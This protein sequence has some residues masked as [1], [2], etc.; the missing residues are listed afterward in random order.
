M[1]EN[2]CIVKKLDEKD[3]IIYQNAIN[4]AFKLLGKKNVSLI[5]HGASFPSA[6]C[7]N[8]GMGSPDNQG[9]KNLVEFI[10]GIF[11]SIQLGPAGKTKAIDSSPYTGTIFSNNTLFIDLLELTKSY[12]AGILP[13]ESFDKI[14]ENNPN[15]GKNKA[16]YS[17]IFAE[18][19][20]A[21]REA[22][23][24]YKLKLLNLD[25]IDKKE[26]STIEVIQKE[27]A[28]YEEENKSWLEKDSLYEAL[29]LKYG[30]DY[31]PMW[32][33]A[34]DKNLF[35][36]KNQED[37]KAS[38]AKIIEIKEQYAD[39][40]EY[41][42]FCQ[43]VAHTQKEA[44]K[45]FA[46]KSN[47][48]MI[49]DRQVA[50]SDRDYWANQALFLDGWN[51]GC[52][53]DYF[54]KDG[55]AWGFPVVNP[56]KIFNEDGSLGAGG[57][58]LKSLFKKMFKENPGGVRIDH[59]IGLIDPWVYKDGKKPK[60]EEGAGRLFSSPEHPEL[61]EF[62][63]A[64][65]DDLDEELESDKEYRVKKLTEKQVK[66]Y[67]ALME[68]LVIEAA[69]EEGLTKNDIICEDLGTLTYPVEQ[70]MKT[71]GLK[72][73]R[74]TQFVVPEKPEHIYRCCNIESSQWAMVG[75]HDNEPVSMWA[76]KMLNTHEGYLH[77]RNLAEDL[78]PEDRKSELDNFICKLT[79]DVELLKKMK[80]VEL[81]ACPAENIQIFF[82]DFFG[83]DDV[84]NRPGTSG[85][86]NW[87][88]RL[89][90]KFE[91][92]YYEQLSKGVGINLP[93]IL[94]LAIE[95]KGQE[96]ISKNENLINELDRLT[97]LLKK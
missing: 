8:T 13:K 34:L 92:F 33:D 24:N 71:Y 55:Q 52:P 11:N 78:L 73:M 58:L 54:S 81:F 5:I 47:I 42:S 27:L 86:K 90:D 82:T 45:D 21:L 44:M 18:Q 37:E 22:F 35:Y 14:V 57:V 3:K 50:F 32:T 31:W 20:K 87:S 10:K 67:G 84:Y 25:S 23:S 76:K 65:M 9:S 96:F 74:L 15:K 19:E 64:T 72:G 43:Y 16:A 49:A 77:A 83:I 60:P 62:A 91:E 56:K 4:K 1:S 36:P 41:Y 7:E 94:K 75:T 12:W 70:V 93:E 38:E 68:K 88:L 30:N 48:K 26:K 40:I 63:I 69:K 6:E 95:T 53:P 39:E 61:K 85:D 79:N 29:C 2:T 17:Y 89:P 51:L 97:A 66:Q 46:L 28:E 59:I 80:L